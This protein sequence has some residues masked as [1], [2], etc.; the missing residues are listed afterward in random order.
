MYNKELIV[1]HLQN[2]ESSLKDIIIWTENINSIDV[3]L[4]SKD[5]MILLNAVCMKLIAIGEEVKGLDKRTDKKLLAQ[6]PDI[7]WKDIMGMR[8]VIAHHYFDIDTEKVFEAI[9]NDVPKLHIVI[10]EILKDVKV[11]N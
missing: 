5:G 2:I 6:Y 1:E 10:K 7:Q 11:K 8:D 3:F 4:T 9:Q